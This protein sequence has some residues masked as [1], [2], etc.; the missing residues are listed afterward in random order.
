MING[1][2]TAA[3][4]RSEQR[5]LRKV[6]PW[7]ST[8][9]LD[10]LELL[11][12]FRD[13]AAECLGRPVNMTRLSLVLEMFSAPKQARG[14]SG[15]AVSAHAGAIQSCNAD[16]APQSNATIQGRGHDAGGFGFGRATT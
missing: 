2:T 11:E 4:R 12:L 10:S 6:P 13:G 8:T 14:A 15:T 3:D 5:V 16:A 9:K 7:S 1:P